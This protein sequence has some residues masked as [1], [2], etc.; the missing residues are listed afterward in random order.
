VPLAN[1]RRCGAK[2][3][4]TANTQARAAPSTDTIS[5][6][7]QPSRSIHDGNA[8]QARDRPILPIAD[9]CRSA[10]TLWISHSPAAF[11][12]PPGLAQAGF[13]LTMGQVNGSS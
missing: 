4:R 7:Y 8:M 1:R 6:H 13:S 12:T 3:T 5:R 9:R 10:T 2:P 11:D